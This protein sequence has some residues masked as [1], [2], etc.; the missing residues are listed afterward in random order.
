MLQSVL[1][2]IRSK[3]NVSAAE[4]EHNDSRQT[5]VLGVSCISNDGRHANSMISNVVNF[6]TETRPDLEL[7]D[8][9][10]ELVSGV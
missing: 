3:F 10:V 8:Y 1:S 4:V 7:I 5:L 9:E 2:R 6:I